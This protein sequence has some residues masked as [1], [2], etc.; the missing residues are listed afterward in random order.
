MTMPKFQWTI[1]LNTVLQVITLAGV[2]GGWIYI[3]ANT[4]RDIDELQAWKVSHELLHKERLA[5]VKA[6]EARQDERTKG[7][8]ADVR[9]L[10]SIT[11][12]LSYR[13]TANEQATSNTSQTVSKIQDTLAQLG[14]DMRLVMEILQRMEAAQ[15][16]GH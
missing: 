9:K 3:W 11:D 15:K 8:E 4:E 6:I 7:I 12:N 10:F 2:V 13:V 5:D 16:R 14:G 1:N